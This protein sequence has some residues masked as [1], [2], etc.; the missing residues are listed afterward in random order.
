MFYYKQ[1]YVC[2]L[3]GV[4]TIYLY[5]MHGATIK[6]QTQRSLPWDRTRESALRSRRLAVTALRSLHGTYV[7]LSVVVLLHRNCQ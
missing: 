7:Q 6:I 2:A 5:E 3:A 1:F 4:L